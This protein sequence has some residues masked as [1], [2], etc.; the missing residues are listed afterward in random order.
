MAKRPKKNK[1]AGEAF[2]KLL[3]DNNFT[4]YK[5]EQATGL[6]KSVITSREQIYEHTLKRLQT[7]KTY[8]MEGLKQEA[9]QQ[10]FEIRQINI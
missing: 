6:D 5:L 9:W 3:K 4:Q 8:V 2:K 1:E 7:F 10:Y